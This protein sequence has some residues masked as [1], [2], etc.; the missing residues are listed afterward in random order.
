MKVWDYFL[1]KTGGIVGW[2]E[3]TTRTRP[4]LAG[5]PAPLQAMNA[6]LRDEY[7]NAL[8]EA[9]LEKGEVR[10]F[11]RRIVTPTP[12]QMA[13]KQKREKTQRVAEALAEKI[14]E[15][16]E[17]SGDFRTL[18]TKLRSVVEEQRG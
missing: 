11:M 15:T 1:D 9:V 17:E 3:G 18:L 7:G 16:L 14:V 13:K 6:G 2:Q 8:W 10:G 4:D 5:T 12:E